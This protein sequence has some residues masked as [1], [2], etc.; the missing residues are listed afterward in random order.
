MGISKGVMLMSRLYKSKD[1]TGNRYFEL[2]GIK[3]CAAEWCEEL[4]IKS[5]T[6]FQRLEK[7]LNPFTGER[8]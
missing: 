8:V 4:G 7:G 2:N 5:S 3:R 6:F 1:I